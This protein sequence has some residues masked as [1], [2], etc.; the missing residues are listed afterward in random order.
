MLK[1]YKKM[2]MALV[3]VIAIMVQAVP[4]YAAVNKVCDG[5][6]VKEVLWETS[7]T[8]S[9]TGGITHKVTWTRETECLICHTRRT[10]L[11]VQY[12]GCN[13]V[14]YTDLGHQSGQSH[15]YRLICGTCGGGYETTITTCEAER[16]GRHAT[17]W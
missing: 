3:C 6:C 11:M 14:K 10:E 17:P 1:K 4:A 12:E 2:I 16:T 5:G 15:R 9:S 8:Y 7:K 13:W